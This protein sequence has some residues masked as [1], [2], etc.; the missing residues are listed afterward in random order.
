MINILAGI[1]IRTDNI[2]IVMAQKKKKVGHC[3]KRELPVT[4]GQ[5]CDQYKPKKAGR[6]KVRCR[7]CTHYIKPDDKINYTGN[8]LTVDENQ[9]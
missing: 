3:Q 6:Y 8:D 1:F 5:L 9:K 7:N 4:A 2:H